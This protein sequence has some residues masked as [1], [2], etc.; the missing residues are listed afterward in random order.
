MPLWKQ[1]SAL[2]AC[3]ERGKLVSVE[4]EHDAKTPEATIY[5]LALATFFAS[6]LLAENIL[7]GGG[8]G[9]GRLAAIFAE[10]AGIA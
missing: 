10:T 5:F 6:L 7:R 1:T 4:W 8:G 2:V 9:G 3:S